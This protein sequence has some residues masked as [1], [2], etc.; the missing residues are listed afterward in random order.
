[1]T[2]GIAMLRAQMQGSDDPEAREMLA[3]MEMFSA[4]LEGGELDIP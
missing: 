3:M 4:M 2:M 1:M